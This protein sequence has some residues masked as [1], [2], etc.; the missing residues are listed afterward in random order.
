[1]CNEL[2]QLD[3]ARVF[4]PDE[5][6]SLEQFKQFLED[7]GAHDNRALRSIL[8]LL[9]ETGVDSPAG[10]TRRCRTIVVQTHYVD[11]WY[12]DAFARLYGRAY[13]DYP[14]TCLRLHFFADR[15]VEDQLLP[16][17]SGEEERRRVDML[18]SS[19]LGYCVLQPSDPDTVGRTVIPPPHTDFPKRMPTVATSNL[20]LFGARLHVD[21]TAFMEQD[22]RVSACAT[23]AI[24]MTHMALYRQFRLRPYSPTQIT[25]LAHQTLRPT[26]RA[27]P[28]EG[29]IVA[30]MAWA[31][32]AM[33]HEPQVYELEDMPV[34][35]ARVIL[36][37][38]LRSSLPVI[39]VVALDA[40]QA[41]MH[42]LT[43]VGYTHGSGP[44]AL[45][46]PG[47]V[48][49]SEWVDGFIAH[50]DQRGPYRL[51]RLTGRDLP[52]I[53]GSRLPEFEL[54]GGYGPDPQEVLTTGAVRTALVPLPEGAYMTAE[55]AVL[56]S[57]R[58]MKSFRG[59]ASSAGIALD[60]PQNMISRTYLIASSDLR[61]A[62]SPEAGLSRELA[63]RY[64]FL[65]MPFALWVTEFVEL[66]PSSA[67]M[68]F[69]APLVAEVL[70]DAVSNPQAGDFVTIHKRPYF[71][72]MEPKGQSPS[73][74]LQDALSR[75]L[76]D[77]TPYVSPFNE[78]T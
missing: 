5:S 74:A 45:P 46:R 70:I 18:Q 61:T 6:E 60:L 58:C 50:D 4:H 17:R 34:S 76:S 11:R 13:R 27:I 59:L 75:P 33:G 10:T 47:P 42:A 48:D 7:R 66:S 51:L 21:G 40:G 52:T 15:L 25:E 30:Q 28:S 38:Y 62:L 53:R 31:L 63:V 1:M 57:H 54:L 3:L 19:Y 68:P 69:R 41:G 32:S 65:P 24:F 26:G 22:R 78:Y 56:K 16:S 73:S 64:R 43:A 55:R 71:A 35:Y 23:V 44:T 20:N 67:T 29:L 2:G 9:L 36:S 8:D 72:H 37:T 14:R 39:F 77:D 12:T 49:A